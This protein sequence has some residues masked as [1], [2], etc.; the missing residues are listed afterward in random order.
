LNF[1]FLT[2][3][4][5]KESNIIRLSDGAGRQFDLA[6]DGTDLK[7]REV[8][9][10]GFET[11][12]DLSALNDFDGKPLQMRIADGQVQVRESQEDEWQNACAVSA[13]DALTPVEAVEPA[14]APFDMDY[15]WIGYILVD[16]PGYGILQQSTN[17]PGEASLLRANN[18]EYR[19]E[20][21]GEFGSPTFAN[22][23]ASVVLG[24]NYAPALY[25]I[26]D[27]GGADIK[28][29]NN[30]GALADLDAIVSIC[31][32]YK[33]TGFTPTE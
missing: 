22:V 33:A 24:P 1:N 4:T 5:M 12:A 11:V 9:T 7:A 18:G 27:G 16:N 15:Y 3:L 6:V 20:F 26:S 28:I 14:G 17:I 29:R 30:S 21:A 10:W 19:L 23:Q 2:F 8:S 13:L 32:L 25:S 31:L